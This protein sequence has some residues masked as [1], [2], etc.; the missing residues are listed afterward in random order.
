MSEDHVS[1][2]VCGSIVNIVEVDGPNH[3]FWKCMNDSECRENL[4]TQQDVS[5]GDTNVR[6]IVGAGSC[7]KCGTDREWIFRATCCPN[8]DL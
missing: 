2:I 4:T 1:C 3:P 7:P 8:C 5:T 6:N